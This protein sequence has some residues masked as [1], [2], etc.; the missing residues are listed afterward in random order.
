MLRALTKRRTDGTL[1]VRR[2][3]IEALLEALVSLDRDSLTDRLSITSR[4]NPLYIPTECLIYFLRE[5]TSGNTFQ[6][7]DTLFGAVERRC[8]AN[9][10][11]AVAAGSVGD[12]EALREDILGRFAETLAKGLHDEPERLDPYEV[13]FDKVFAALR[14]DLVRR[15]RREVELAPESRNEDGEPRLTQYRQPEAAEDFGMSDVEFEVFRKQISGT[16]SEL[17]DTLSE[18]I[19]LR[20]Q[21]L[22]IG[23]EDPNVDTIAKRS[24]VDERTIRNRIKRGVEKI[25][26]I[27]QGSLP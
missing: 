7:F 3:E 17:P 11:R 16:I 26:K 25:N 9:L 20:L 23:S 4:V 22:P 15:Q 5:A 18:A 19:L 6:W 13:V 8:R 10:A 12:E 14:I 27:T 21:G 1:Y 2:P 24:G